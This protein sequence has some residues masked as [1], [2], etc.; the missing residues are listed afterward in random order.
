MPINRSQPVL[1]VGGAGFIG[2]HMVLSLQEAGYQPI[3]LD[4]LCK[5]HRDAVINAELIVGDMADGALLDSLFSKH[6]FLAVMHFASYIEVGESVQQP[7]KYYQNNVAATLT[8]LQTML[9]HHVKHFIFSSSAAV[10][11]EPQYTPI[12]EQ[13]PL[14]PI[15]P[16]GRSKRMVE[17]MLADFAKSDGLH[18]AAL[19]YFNAAGA[20]PQ[21]RLS[22]RHEP[23]SHLIPLI[24]QAVN[25][26]RPAITVYGR[27]Y[28]TADGTCIR[29]YVHVADLCHAHLLALEYLVTKQNSI[30]CNLG[31]GH[32]YSVQQVIDAVARVTGKPIPMIDGARR[33]GDPAVLVA[34]ASVAKRE[35]NWQPQYDNLE[36]IV[37]HAGRKAVAIV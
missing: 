9:K 35:L 19:R 25:G 7:G 1:V 15:N 13:H 29:D 32:G 10:Y 33:I 4:N 22:E 27:D 3:V 34:D 17:E 21:G 28:S 36:T 12:N 31:T 14:A 30:I 26:Q 16:Y 20:D 24:L 2:S 37:R 23:E 8:L 11:G 18:Y 5:G 6:Q